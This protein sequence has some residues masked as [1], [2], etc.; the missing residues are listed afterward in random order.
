[1][2]YVTPLL[3]LIGSASA[4]VRAISELEHTKENQPFTDSSSELEGEW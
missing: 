3:T 1:M 2:A 4:T